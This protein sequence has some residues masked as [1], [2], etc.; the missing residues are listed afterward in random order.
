MFIVYIETLKETSQN[1]FVYM[2]W[3][4]WQNGTLILCARSKET[5]KQEAERK[6]PLVHCYQETLR[7]VGCS[8]KTQTWFGMRF[9]LISTSPLFWYG[10]KPC[11]YSMTVYF[12][13][14]HR[15]TQ[16]LC[17]NLVAPFKIYNLVWPRDDLHI[18][19]VSVCVAHTSNPL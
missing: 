14:K 15:L 1:F 7:S 11:A 10:K 13:V 5:N 6:H 19:I 17:V 3:L 2:K 12:L 4:G 18:L 9:V 8:G 16:L